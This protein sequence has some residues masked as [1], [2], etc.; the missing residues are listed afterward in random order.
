MEIT[1]FFPVICMVLS[2]YACKVL[3]RS[4]RVTRRHQKDKLMGMQL[5]HLAVADLVFS[6]LAIPLFVLQFFG[7]NNVLHIGRLHGIGMDAVC[8]AFD[9]LIDAGLFTSCIV[10]VHLSVTLLAVMTRVPVALA[11]LR[12]LLPTTWLIGLCLSTYESYRVQVYWS[13]GCWIHHADTTGVY[14]ELACFAVSLT[15]Y[16]LCV[17]QLVCCLKVGH[18]VERKVWSRVHFFI[19]AWFICNLPRV[20]LIVASYFDFLQYYRSYPPYTIVATCLLNLNGAANCLVYGF[21]GGY[22]ERLRMRSRSRPIAVSGQRESF[23][24]TVGDVTMV[25]ISPAPSMTSPE[26]LEEDSSEHRGAPRML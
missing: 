23:C 19:V 1:L 26:P 3:L 25:S 11:I 15:V 16:V 20:L 6:L 13:G 7:V 5:W 24:V 18:H 14:V 10:T 8:F 21:Q 22:M 2:A 4:L 17:I 9:A 12:R